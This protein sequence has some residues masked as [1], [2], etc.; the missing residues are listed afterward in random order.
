MHLT[1]G[2]HEATLF[3]LAEEDPL[4]MR[5][6]HTLPT[7]NVLEEAR[8]GLEVRRQN[9]PGVNLRIW[10]LTF[11]PTSSRVEAHAETF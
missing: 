2:Q 3:V 9:R 6:D 8:I 7:Y 11:K 1:V 5:G 10:R 4:T